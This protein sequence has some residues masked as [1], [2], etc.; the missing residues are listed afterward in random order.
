M[1]IRADIP[2]DARHKPNQLERPTIRLRML[3]RLHMP[4]K[5]FAQRIYGQRQDY[6]EDD[7]PSGECPIPTASQI[8]TKDKCVIRT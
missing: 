7:N 1:F 5:L 4:V 6:T 2:N 8:L 3:L